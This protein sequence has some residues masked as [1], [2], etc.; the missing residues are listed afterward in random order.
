MRNMAVRAPLW[1]VV[2][3]FLLVPGCT[4][5][6]DCKYELDQKIRTANAWSTFDP[7]GCV[8]CDYKSGWKAGYYDVITGGPGCPPVIAPKKYWKTPVFCEHDPSKRNDWYCGF[9][10]GAACAKCEPDHHYLEAFLPCQDA[11]TVSHFQHVPAAPPQ[12]FPIQHLSPDMVPAEPI[13]LQSTE[14]APV[15]PE[16]QSK[17]ESTPKPM[18]S[19]DPGYDQDPAPGDAAPI[20]PPIP[21]KVP[22]ALSLP[23]Q[24]PV[25]DQDYSSE[26]T[27][28]ERLVTNAASVRGH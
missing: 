17:P 8:S 14:P 23:F 6:S 10:D 11:V 27:F 3:L 15:S 7:G 13:P 18:P 12:Q 5:I 19:I 2:A 4:C 25:A 16:T 9:Q 22:Q 1:K 20:N 21:E 24:S 26:S 28:V